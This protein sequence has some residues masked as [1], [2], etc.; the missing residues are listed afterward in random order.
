MARLA[1]LSAQMARYAVAGFLATA[2]HYALMAILFRQGW[3]PVSASTAGAAAGAV[4]AY[5]VNRKWTFEASHTMAR[6]V[7]FMAVAA[8]GL[9]LNAT[10]LVT[11]HQWLIPSI[12]GAQLLTT[13][14]V[15]V[16]TFFINQK[17]SFR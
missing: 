6:M 16:A 8:L 4:V 7:R 5:L 13:L 2:T 1:G 11:I 12:I 9:L 3:Y 14:L 15:F 10:L 17:W